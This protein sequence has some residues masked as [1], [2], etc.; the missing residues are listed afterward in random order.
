MKP[1]LELSTR[2]R[3][4]ADAI[5]KG[6]RLADVGTDHGQLLAWLATRG[7]LA[8]GIGL[9]INEGPLRQAQQTLRAA[10]IDDIELR[11]GDGLEPLRPGEVQTV[12]L[13]GMGGA[14]M[15]RLVDAAPAVVAQLDRLVLQPN[16]DWAMVR[17]WIATHG[18][19]LHSERM[20]EDRGKFYVVLTVEPR[21]QPEPATWT[22]DDYVL[23]PQ[24]RRE[25]P[26]A[27][28]AWLAHERERIEQALQRAAQRRD[29]AAGLPQ[30]EQLRERLRRVIAAQ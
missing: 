14:T 29:H 8:A 25:R 21:P 16:T 30:D 11:L 26:A 12:A 15:M 27:F 7:Q 5:G 19:P 4:V 2:L 6:T 1:R 10:Q 9:D 23:G 18:W 17:R 13:A 24:L 20:V 3:A 22:A 28:V